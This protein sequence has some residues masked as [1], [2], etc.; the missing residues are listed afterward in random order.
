MSIGAELFED[1]RQRLLALLKRL[2]YEEREV[3]LASGA[4]EQL[5]HRLQADGADRR[6]PFPGG[7]LFGRVLAEQA[8]RGG[9]DWR[10]DDGRRSAR[11][12]G[13]DPELPRRPAAARLLRA[14]G[15][16]GPRHRRLDRGDEVAAAR[17][18]RWPS[19]RTSSR[20]AAR[21]SR[22]SRGFA[23]TGSR[24]R[25]S[26][27]WSIA[28]EGGREVARER[29]AP[30]QPVPPQRFQMRGD[31]SGTLGG[32]PNPPAMGSKPRREDPPGDP[33][34]GKPSLLHAGS[35]AGA[36]GCLS[37]RRGPAG[38]CGTNRSAS[39][40]PRRPATTSPR[41]TKASSSGGP[42]TDCPARGR[43]RARGLGHV[44]ELGLSRGVRGALRVDLQ[45]VGRRS[46]HAPRRRSSRTSAHA[47]E[48]TVV[49]AELGVPAGTIRRSRA[50]PGG[51]RWST[52]LGTSSRRTRSG[53]EASGRL[54]V[55]VLPHRLSGPGG[56]SVKSYRIASRCPPP[57]S[58][59]G[60]S[61][62]P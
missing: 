15:G 41:I 5:L 59:S 31:N 23:S 22:P 39:T 42:A 19:S 14:Q 17:G 16:Q 37:A 7:S 61:R 43:H 28:S 33:G 35:G 6:G 57:V 27:G 52:P 60:R 11:L 12:R 45:P 46:R 10:G 20:P 50:R 56:I 24:S 4:E 30:R 55:A 18:C 49:G 32:F 38:A 48:F 3:T 2:S 1:N 8:P 26:W 21:R 54:P 29:G 47:Y 25:S 58:S 53:R 13:F 9:S 62:V 51:S 44:Q 40:S 36:G 34:L